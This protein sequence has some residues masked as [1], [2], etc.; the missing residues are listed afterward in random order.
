ML[1]A[2][3]LVGAD[4]IA[5]LMPKQLE[6]TKW[7]KRRHNSKKDRQ[8]NDHKKQDKKTNNDQS[9]TT[10]KSKD[11]PTRTPLQKTKT[12]T[13]TGCELFLRIQN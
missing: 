6:D 11:Y 13:K 4:K 7:L 9:N 8:N 3:I 5:T 12:K 1:W 2:I 10:Q